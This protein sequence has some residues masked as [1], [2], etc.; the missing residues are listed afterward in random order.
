MQKSSILCIEW[1]KRT[2]KILYLGTQAGIVKVYDANL[3]KVIQEVPLTKHLPIVTNISSSA[4]NSKWA[5]KKFY[6]FI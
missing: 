2:N 1:V 5:N 3:K 4:L 6:F